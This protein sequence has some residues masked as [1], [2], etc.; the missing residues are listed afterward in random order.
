MSSGS[1]GLSGGAEIP[2]VNTKQFVAEKFA[3][4]SILA[5]NDITNPILLKEYIVTQDPNQSLIQIPT[6]WIRINSIGRRISGAGQ[7]IFA[8][9]S[10]GDGGVTW[11]QQTG[12]QFAS[13]GFGAA[14]ASVSFENIGVDVNRIAVAFI[15]SDGVSVGEIKEAKCQFGFYL[16]LNW[17][18]AEV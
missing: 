6:M 5:V 10:S 15:N 13:A 3:L 9:F 4:T 16:P 1:G 11:I 14:A 2:T 18:I 17:K 12:V 8:I 7:I